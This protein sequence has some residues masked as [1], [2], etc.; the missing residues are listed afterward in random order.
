MKKADTEAQYMRLKDSLNQVMESIFKIE[1]TAVYVRRIL[2][3]EQQELRMQ[4]ALL[5]DYQRKKGWVK[6]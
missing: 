4:M 1:P 3:Q 5:K 6:S 2:M